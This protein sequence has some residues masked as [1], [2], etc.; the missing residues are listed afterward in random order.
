MVDLASENAAPQSTPAATASGR[1]RQEACTDVAR[2][3]SLVSGSVV[4]A[5][6]GYP[7]NSDA[8]V[9]STVRSFSPDTTDVPSTESAC[10]TVVLTR[11]AERANEYPVAP[12]GVHR[13]SSTDTRARVIGSCDDTK[14][15]PSSSANVSGATSP[16]SSLARAYALFFCESVGSTFALDPLRC[17]SARSPDRDVETFRSRMRSAPHVPAPRATCT[18]RTSALLYGLAP[19]WSMGPP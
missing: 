3:R 2:M 12:I 18:S 14:N 6:F 16:P 8:V 15:D 13:Y 7:Q 10:T 11:S 1:N 9:F 19:S 5:S 4:Y 17:V